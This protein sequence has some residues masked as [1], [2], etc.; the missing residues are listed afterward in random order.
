M[1]EEAPAIPEILLGFTRGVAPS[2]WGKRWRAVSPQPL[3]IVPFPRPYG[4]PGNASDFDMLL[5]RTAPGQVPV[6]TE[7][8]ATRTHHALRLYDEALAIVLP[9]G[10]ELTGVET[11]S[12]AELADVRILDHPNHSPAWPA[13]EP[14]ADPA[15]MPA[16]ITAALDVVA[17][18]LGGILMPAPLARHITDKHQHLTIRISDPVVGGTVWASWPVER[19]APDMQHLAGVMRGRTARSSRTVDAAGDGAGG[20]RAGAAGGGAGSGSGDPQKRTQPAQKKKPKLN[21]NSRGAQ[22]QA[23]KEKREREKAERRKAKRR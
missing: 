1:N 22:L 4:R 5:E 20:A 9:K 14:W 8:H 13:P 12:L 23:A 7:D 18:G 17:T 10:H 2:K 16:N 19:D 11:I 21:P 3:S 15:W 6:G